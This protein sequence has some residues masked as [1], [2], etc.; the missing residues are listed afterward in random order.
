LLTL[1]IQRKIDAVDI[2]VSIREG[3]KKPNRLF[4]DVDK[5]SFDTHP[6]PPKD[7]I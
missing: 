1:S 6:P 4:S 7:D 5:I 3:L 2:T